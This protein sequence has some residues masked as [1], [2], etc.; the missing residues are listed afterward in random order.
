MVNIQHLSKRG[1]RQTNPMD[2]TEHAKEGITNERRHNSESITVY[3][4]VDFPNNKL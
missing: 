4:Y 1:H 3:M 2:V